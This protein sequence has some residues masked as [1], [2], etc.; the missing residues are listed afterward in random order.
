MSCRCCHTLCHFTTFSIFA[1]LMPPRL[2]RCLSSLYF[3]D[4][5]IFFAA[6]FFRHAFMLMLPYAAATLR[7]L[8]SPLRRCHFD[9]F[10]LLIADARFSL[11]FSSISSFCLSSLFF[12]RHVTALMSYSTRLCRGVTQTGVTQNAR[13]GYIYVTAAPKT[14]GAY[15][16]TPLFM[17]RAVTASAHKKKKDD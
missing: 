17:L 10:L 2:F 6:D 7:F 5:L 12:S 3:I 1:I 16:P 11:S 8:F 14:Y 9:C 15:E 13:R 4:F